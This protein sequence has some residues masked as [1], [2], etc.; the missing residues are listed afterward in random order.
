MRRKQPGER[1]SR[2]DE[3]VDE[4]KRTRTAR[5]VSNRSRPTSPTRIR[6]NIMKTISWSSFAEFFGRDQA[7]PGDQ[8]MVNEE[9]FTVSSIDK[10]G[11]TF[12]VIS[13]DDEED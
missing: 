13:V 5:T 7:E 12:E 1:R 11:V 2:R 4:Q 3:T 10:E 6:S 8:M 9:L